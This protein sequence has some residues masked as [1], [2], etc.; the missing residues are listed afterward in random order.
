MRCFNVTERFASILWNGLNFNVWLD[1]ART[2]TFIPFLHLSF[3]LVG[4]QNGLIR[5]KVV[6]FWIYF[7]FFTFGEKRYFRCFTSHSWNMLQRW[8]IGGNGTPHVNYILFPFSNFRPFPSLVGLPFVSIHLLSLH[9]HGEHVRSVHRRWRQS[10]CHSIEN[11]AFFSLLFSRMRY[12]AFNAWHACVC[13][14][15]PIRMAFR[16]PGPIAIHRN[17]LCTF[18]YAIPFS[19]FDLSSDVWMWRYV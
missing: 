12:S 2:Q 18:I 16:W 3:S 15:L 13:V 4:T 6:P 5:H 8:C 7:Y 17:A 10:K 1:S 19:T 9:S 14:L 11:A